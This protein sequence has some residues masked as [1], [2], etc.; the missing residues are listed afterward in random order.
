MNVVEFD[1]QPVYLSLQVA[2]AAL[3]LVF[4][5]ATLAALWMAHREF[6]GKDIVEAVFLLPL[7]LP[8]VV[9]GYALL[10]LAGKQGPLGIWL[11][12]TFHFR[13]IFTPYAAILA[14]SFVAF[15]LMYQ[16]AKAAFLVLDPQL[17]D[18]ARALGAAPLRVF[19]TIVLPLSWPG[20]VAGAV[21]SFARA[22]GE[23][24]ATIMVA[25]NIVG[26]TTTMPTAIYMAAENGD[27][28]VA[29]LYSVA[30]AVF[31]LLFIIGLNI[32]LRRR[33]V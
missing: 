20:L 11:E 27:L 26:Q 4:I 5:T 10:V 29:G 24:G 31:N 8:P 15:P 14:S 25:G 12:N 16:S 21:L 22:L 28:Q 3:A 19:W 30:L 32:W 33:R 13:L 17:P 23:F 1:W 9:T 2:T 7:V 18:A 6:W